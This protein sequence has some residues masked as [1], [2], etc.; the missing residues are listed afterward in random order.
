M[1]RKLRKTKGQNTAEYAILFAIVIGGAVGLQAYMGRAQKA[2]GHDAVKYLMRETAGLVPGGQREEQFEPGYI[3]N[4]S[5]DVHRESESNIT[6]DVDEA[7]A[8]STA[9]S[10]RAT[11]GYQRFEY[12]PGG[13]TQEGMTPDQSPN[14]PD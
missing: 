8:N 3:V 1:F 4:S 2:T 14:I 13:T 10:Q 9:R 11:G 6:L 12:T 7:S 5:F